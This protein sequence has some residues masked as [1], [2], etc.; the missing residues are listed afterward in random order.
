MIAHHTSNGCPLRP[1]DLIG[2]GTISGPEPHNR[3]CLL[4]LTKKGR[5]PIKLP[6]GRQRCFL[7]DGDTVILHACCH[8]EHFA[9]IGFGACSGQI[10]A[11]TTT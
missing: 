9:D 7:E 2:S 10:L 8:R 3:G 6:D 11:A 5:A 1:G 4:E